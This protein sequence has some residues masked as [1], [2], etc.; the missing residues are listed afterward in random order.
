MIR[1]TARSGDAS[2]AI[3][4]VCSWQ[5]LFI[6]LFF[7]IFESSSNIFG[8]SKNGPFSLSQELFSSFKHGR[9]FSGFR[10][11]RNSIEKSKFSEK[12]FAFEIEL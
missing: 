3:T 11:L 1:T 10:F 4:V 8:T 5:E 9:E 6:F 12:S 7:E 2:L